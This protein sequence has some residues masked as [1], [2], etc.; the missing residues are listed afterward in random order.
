MLETW[1]HFSC[2]L[3]VTSVQAMLLLTPPKCSAPP[4]KN[5]CSLSANMQVTMTS[6][7]KEDQLAE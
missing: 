5:L 1:R 4:P 2:L 3:Q 6:V 7:H